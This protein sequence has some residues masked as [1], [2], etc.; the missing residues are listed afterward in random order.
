MT[1]PYRSEHRARQAADTRQRIV[2]ALV[3]QVLEADRAD[4]AIADVAERAG[5]SERTVYRYFPT[6]EDLL[7]AIDEHFTALPSP[8]L[9]KAIGD[10][11]DHVASLYD[12]FAENADFVRAVH[13]TGLGREVHV[14]GRT[15]RGRQ[16]RQQ[17]DR[18]LA[19]LSEAERR[20]LFAVLRATFGSANWRALQEEGGLDPEEAREAAVWMARLVTRD[21]ESRLRAVRGEGDG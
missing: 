11:P 4:F 9:P 21:I 3:E 17:L 5:V 7:R 6:R 12:G 20:R 2:E 13:V 8:A 19:S 14:R 16:L 15:R 10:F 18:E 1:R